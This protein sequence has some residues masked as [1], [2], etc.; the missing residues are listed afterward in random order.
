MRK[1]YSSNSPVPINEQEANVNISTI[2]VS[3]LEGKIRDVNVTLDIDHTW[4]S[5]LKI[6]IVSPNNAQ[7]LLVGRRGD[8]GDNFRGTK[9][10]D[11]AEISIN[12]ASAPFG[13]T[14]RPEENLSKFN[15]QDPNGTWTLRM[16]DMASG[17]GGQLNRWEIS[18]ETGVAVFRN[19]TPVPISTGGPNTISSDIHVLGLDGLRVEKISVT[20]NIDHTWDSDLKVSLKSPEGTSVVLANKRGNDGDGFRTTFTDDADTPIGQGQSPFAGQFQPEENLNN[21]KHQAAR[22]IWTLIVEDTAN[23]DGGMLNEWS[24]E[25]DARQEAPTDESKFFVEV[26]IEG[27][28]TPNQREVFTVAARRWSQIIVGDL[29]SMS[30][31][32]GRVVDDV[33]IHAKGAFIDGTG[34]ILGHAG[35]RR[36]RPPPSLLPYTG[37]MSFDS[38]DLSSMEANGSLLEVIIHEMAHVLGIGTIWHEKGL[39]RGSGSANPV[40]IG[41]N[42]MREYQ[43]LINA[44]EPTPVPIANTGGPGTREGHWREL[45]FGNELMTGFHGQGVV[46]PISRLTIACLEDLGY[47]VNYDAADDFEIPTS[48]MLASLGTGENVTHRNCCEMGSPEQIVASKRAFVKS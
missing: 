28:L 39:I 14:Y 27:G 17:D 40:F 47:E 43:A 32:D 7:V 8:D 15:D 30:L 48:L 20:V 9:F 3:G 6:F 23:Q 16:E 4:T 19:K 41:Q 26:E 2:D 45:V 37:V 12:S 25:L 1:E 31:S 13:G 22:G 10:D 35:P 46:N 36:K 33:L 5:D 11:A 18:L 21:F 44:A 42:A 38:S 29:P 24:I 34:S